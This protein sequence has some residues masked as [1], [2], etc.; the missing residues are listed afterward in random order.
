MFRKYVLSGECQADLNTEIRYLLAAARVDGLDLVRLDFP[1]G[2]SEKDSSRIACCVIKV[3]RAVKRD[4]CIQFYV[5]KEG[6]AQGS[7]E[8]SYLM[9]KFSTYIDFD[10]GDNYL[11]IRL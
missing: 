10:E 2:D 9:N 11:Y 8:A 3:M 6:F 1:K 7:T 5:N 4:G